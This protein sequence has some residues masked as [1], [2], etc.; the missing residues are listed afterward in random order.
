MSDAVCCHKEGWPIM[1]PSSYRC[2]A[3]LG[4]DF[5]GGLNCAALQVLSQRFAATDLGNL[6]ARQPLY[7]RGF[8]FTQD[9]VHPSLQMSLNLA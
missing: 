4:R 1:Q 5:E 9:F 8:D 7:Q 2:L 3:W 6:R